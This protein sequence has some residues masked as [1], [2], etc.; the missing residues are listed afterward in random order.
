MRSI[1]TLAAFAC[2][3]MAAVDAANGC[4]YFGWRCGDTCIKRG[5][6]CFCGNVEI[7]ARNTDGYE[8]S[9]YCCTEKPCEQRGDQN[10]TKFTTATTTD[11]HLGGN[12][13]HG[14][15]LKLWDAC[16]TSLETP[17]QP[18]CNHYPDSE[19]APS[20]RSYVPCVPKVPGQKIT[21]CIEKANEGD[22]VYF[23]CYNRGDENPFLRPN[24]TNI[25]DLS[26]LLK[27]CKDKNEIE[28]YTCPTFDFKEEQINCLDTSQWCNEASSYTC[29]EG[30]KTWGGDLKGIK[31]TD[32]RI[33]GNFEFW[34]NQ[35][36]AVGLK[37]MQHRCT[38]NYPGQ[39]VYNDFDET[40]QVCKDK[41]D[42]NVP[43]PA[44]G[45]Q[46]AKK[47]QLRC[48]SKMTFWLDVE[49]DYD[50]PDAT[51]EFKHKFICIEKASMC[52]GTPQCEYGED[53]DEAMCAERKQKLR[54]AT[55]NFAC[56]FPAYI[57]PKGIKIG[58]SDEERFLYVSTT[59][60]IR[61]GVK[62]SNE[63]TFW[64]LTSTW[65]IRCDGERQC[66]NGEDELDCLIIKETLKYAVRK[67]FTCCLVQTETNLISFQL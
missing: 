16:I 60:K 47:D 4:G 51:S 13:T 8:N 43:A 62:L 56:P 61:A 1:L 55:E 18:A 40:E 7:Q 39:C 12:C 14:K 29:G 23:H 31:V 45:K 66:I 24:K 36:C 10:I 9:E 59:A 34:E 54:D 2:F 58:E 49:Y 38:G 48:L 30:N 26:I 11:D 6:P 27:K 28:G 3:S 5:A 20:P 63:S 64:R 19:E 41:S 65:A 17:L 32:P 52:D 37:Q 57:I 15:V 25:L 35:E 21:K 42:I 22:D 33:C 50:Y 44:M 53:E 67:Y 46:C